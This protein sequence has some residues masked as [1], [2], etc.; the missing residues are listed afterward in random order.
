MVEF[1][2][3]RDNDKKR[4][5]NRKKCLVVTLPLLNHFLGLASG[6]PSLLGPV[7]IS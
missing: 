3:K 1:E 4:L 5:S 7:P 6:T 2:R